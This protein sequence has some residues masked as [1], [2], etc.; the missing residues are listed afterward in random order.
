MDLNTLY[1]ILGI[2]FY[3]GG[4]VKNLLDSWNSNE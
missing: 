2:M 3:I 4:I 1:L